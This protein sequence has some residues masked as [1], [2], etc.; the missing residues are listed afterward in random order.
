[1]YP[2]EWSTWSINTIFII[3]K[4]TKYMNLLYSTDLRHQSNRELVNIV[5]ETSSYNQDIELSFNDFINS[6]TPA[7]RKFADAIVELYKRS[8]K[9]KSDST[10][11]TCSNSI[12]QVMRPYLTGLQVEEFWVIFMNTG[13][14]IIKIQNFSKG[15]LN[16]TVVDV[17]LVMQA[18]LQCGSTTMALVHNHPSSVI[19]PSMQDDNITEKIKKAAAVFDIRLL[20]HVIYADG[21]NFYSYAD[22]GKI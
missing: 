9:E 16:S 17:R 2:G 12:Y 5:S 7:K 13:A 21:G 4:S 6:L 15:G 19:T 3:I 11:I 1:M 8:L 14:K 20:D 10:K 22:E 18:A